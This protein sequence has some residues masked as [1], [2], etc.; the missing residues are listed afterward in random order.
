MGFLLVILLI[1]QVL[2]LTGAPDRSTADVAA[3]ADSMDSVVPV[4]DA[5]EV[6]AE[7]WTAGDGGVAVPLN[8]A[9]ESEAGYDDVNGSAPDEGATL[10][11]RFA[12]SAG[13]WPVGI[14]FVFFVAR[15]RKERLLEHPVRRRIMEEVRRQPGIHHRQ[16]LRVLGVSN[17]TLAYHLLQ[18]E[19]AGC[20]RFSCAYGRKHLIA[21]G[22]QIAG[23]EFLITDR[24]RDLLALLPE[25]HVAGIEEL[26]RRLGLKESGVA[27]HLGRLRALGFV[28]ARRERQSLVFSRTP[29]SPTPKVRTTNH[30]PAWPY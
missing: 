28:Q 11:G 3:S 2:L 15:I 20:H 26:G 7:S 8:A 27:Y 16:L 12:P 29:G 25:A 23:Q 1:P 10:D 4:A 30:I 24:D 9:E 22:D 6:S 14:P 21:P 5:Y 18:M 17:G 19:R 13:I